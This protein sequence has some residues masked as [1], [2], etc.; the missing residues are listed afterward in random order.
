MAS[1]GSAHGHHL[2]TMA[3]GGKKHHGR[4]WQS[5]GAHLVEQGSREVGGS[6]RGGQPPDQGPR[7]K[8]TSHPSSR[9]ACR[10]SSPNSPHGCGPVDGLI[11]PRRSPDL[12]NPTSAHRR[13]RGHCRMSSVNSLVYLSVFLTGVQAV[14]VF[15]LDTPSRA[16][17][18][19]V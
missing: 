12:Q 6:Q 7:N 3:P 10:S 4:A 11:S 1:E 9:P 18:V 2:P 13:L 17:L 19:A 5:A 8:P 15:T 14:W 16:G